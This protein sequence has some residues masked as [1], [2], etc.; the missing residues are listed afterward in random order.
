MKVN[1]PKLLPDD[2]MFKQLLDIAMDRIAD[3]FFLLQVQVRDFVDASAGAVVRYL[4]DGN[5]IDSRDYFYV[6]TDS[7][8]NTVTVTAFG[9]QTI[10]GSATYVL[11]AQYD[12][13]LLVFDKGTQ[14]WYI[15]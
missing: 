12:R 1:L 5:N 14:T 7:S 8:V 9:T 3:G 13:V 6:K 4:P 10:V 11:A 15:Q 2:K